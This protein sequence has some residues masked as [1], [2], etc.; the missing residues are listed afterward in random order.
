MLEAVREF[1]AERLETSPALASRARAAHAR[2]YVGWVSERVGRMAHES[3]A[4][5]IDEIELEVDNLRR[6]WRW[7]VEDEDLDRLMALHAGLRPLYDARGW[8]RGLIGLLDDILAVLED[9]PASP[10]RVVTVATLQSQ[11]ARAMASAD[12]YTDEV[13]TAFERVLATIEGADLSDAYPV[14]RSLATFYTFRMQHDQALDLARQILA[15]GE[16]QGD[17]A[18]RISGHMLIGTSM[19]FLG[20][21]TDGLPDLDAAASLVAAAPSSIDWYRLGPDPRVSTLTALSLIHFWQGRLETSLQD[22]HEVMAIA[23]S[24]RHPSTLGYGLHHTALLHTMRGEPD[25]AREYAVEVIELATEHDLHIWRAVGTAVL[26][27][28]MTALGASEEGMRWIREGLERYRGLRTPPVFWPFMLELTANA[29]HR[30]GETDFGLASIEEALAVAPQMPGLYLAKGD[31]L[32]AR[33]PAAA[34]A[35]YEAALGGSLGWGAATYALAAAMR[36]FRLEDGSDASLAEARR[37]QV[38]ELAASFSEGL[39]VPLLSEAHAIVDD[40]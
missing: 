7:A 11:R 29:C 10:D 37:E 32:T 39:E 38:R 20:R 22:A 1:A 34:A 23:R 19:S 21:L 33:D 5:L 17:V 30:S 15:L 3:R 8:Y 9:L 36:L 25:Q 4:E 16:V 2:Y 31:L 12:G 26:G 27:A 18:M 35:A 24:G 40:A 6:A 14:L 13:E 28:A